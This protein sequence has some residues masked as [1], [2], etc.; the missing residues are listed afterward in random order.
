MQQKLGTIRAL[1]HDPDLFILDEPVSALD[2]H[3]V[4]EIRRLLL[5]QAQQGKTIFISSHILS[6][7]E[8]DG[9]PD[10]HHEQRPAGC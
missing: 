10:R 8:A 3:G 2:P 1:L 7:V 4:V 9:R 6:E 5:D